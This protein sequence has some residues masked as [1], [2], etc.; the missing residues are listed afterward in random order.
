M[1]G[2]GLSLSR[3][4]TATAHIFPIALAMLPDFGTGSPIVESPITWMLLCLTDSYV[5]WLTSHQRLSAPTR[6]AVTAIVPARCGGIRLSTSYFTL[7]PSS[8]VTSRVLGSTF[9]TL[10]EPRYSML[11]Y[12][13]HAARNSAVFEM[14]LGFA[15]STMSFDFGLVF[16]RYQATWHVR[17]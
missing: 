15:S 10:F 2:T 17:S 7:T 5:R 12:A 16:F 9:T 13:A 4:A 1:V 6:S 8:V 14:M 3:L 11:G